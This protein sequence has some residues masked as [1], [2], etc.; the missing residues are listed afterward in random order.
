MEKLFIINYECN[1]DCVF[2]NIKGNQECLTSYNK[3]VAEIKKMKKGGPG[4]G[5]TGG[6]PTLFPKLTTLIRLCKRQG[7]LNVVLTTNGYLFANPAYTKKIERTGLDAVF[8]PIHSYKR[9][10][11]EKITRKNGS[12]DKCILGVKNIMKSNI[13]IMFNLVINR[14][15][16]KELEETV[17][18]INREFGKYPISFSFVQPHGAARDNKSIVPRMIDIKPYLVRSMRLAQKLGITFEISGCSVPACMVPGFEKFSIERRDAGDKNFAAEMTRNK[19][20][21]PKCCLCVHDK[22]C[23]GVWRQYAKMYGVEELKP[24]K[25]KIPKSKNNP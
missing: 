5:I 20:K 10:T 14:L 22:K 13:K 17:R 7:V 21:S 16:Y 23:F 3:A 18:F 19:I 11:F 12:Y 6:E 15:N 9:S 25:R 24:V 4:V 8:I 2:C 1:F